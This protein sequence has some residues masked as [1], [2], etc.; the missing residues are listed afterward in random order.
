MNYDSSTVEF[1]PDSFTFLTNTELKGNLFKPCATFVVGKLLNDPSNSDPNVKLDRYGFI[2]GKMGSSFSPTADTFPSGSSLHNRTYLYVAKA[3]NHGGK[4]YFTFGYDSCPLDTY[5]GL[6]GDVY[7]RC[8]LSCD[9]QY[10]PYVIQSTKTLPSSG[11]HMWNNKSA[12][13]GTQNYEAL[14]AMWEWMK[15][16]DG[17]RVTVHLKVGDQNSSSVFYG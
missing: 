2:N 9:G 10:A 13:V 15:A 5:Y 11:W 12:T 4:V 3:V 17:T 1:I 7:I 8:A 6:F 16:N 14:N